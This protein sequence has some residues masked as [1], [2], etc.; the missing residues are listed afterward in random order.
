MTLSSMFIHISIYYKAYILDHI[1]ESF[2]LILI[3]FFIPT[4]HLKIPIIHNHH[5][6]LLNEDL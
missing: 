4:I 3:Y 2:I 5:K 1:M 6:S